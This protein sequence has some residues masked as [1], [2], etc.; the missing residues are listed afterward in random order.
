MFYFI[1][2]GV[3]WVLQ[4]FYDYNKNQVNATVETICSLNRKYRIK[5]WDGFKAWSK[6]DESQVINWIN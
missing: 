6:L 1:Y 4:W 2:I 5:W 3:S